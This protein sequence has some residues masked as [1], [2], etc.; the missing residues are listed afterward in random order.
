MIKN[1]VI[2]LVA[3]AA[4][5][6]V[7]APAFADTA[8]GDNNTLEMRDFLQDSAVA[9]LNQKGINA[10]EVEDWNGL[11]RAYVTLED[12]TQTMQFYTPGSLEQVTF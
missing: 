12:G 11:V 4:M 7:A 8:F 5:A 9:Q 6:G 2:A 3:A 1:T 10:T